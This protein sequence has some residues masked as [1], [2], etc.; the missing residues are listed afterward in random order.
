[1]KTQFNESCTKE[2]HGV[3]TTQSNLYNPKPQFFAES[4]ISDEH[5]RFYFWK[6]K[7]G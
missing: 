4:T 7:E 5:F 2:E 3:E 6:D 1:M